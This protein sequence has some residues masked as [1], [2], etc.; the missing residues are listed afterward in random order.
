MSYNPSVTSPSGM[1]RSDHGPGGR[2]GRPVGAARNE[3]TVGHGG[4]TVPTTGGRRGSLSFLW[5]FFPI[6]FAL[7]AKCGADMKVIS[8]IELHQTEVIGQDSPALRAVGRANGSR[9]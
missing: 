4:A 1:E 2:R 9:A 5:S 7:P 8:F 3:A 6:F